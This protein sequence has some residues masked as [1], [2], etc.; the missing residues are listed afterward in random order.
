MNREIRLGKTVEGALVT[1]EMRLERLPDRVTTVEHEVIEP[2][3]TD[4]RFAITGCVYADGTMSDT[5]ANV[6]SAGQCRDSLL[7]IVLPHKGWNLVELLELHDFW[8]SWHLNDMH[9]ACAHMKLPKDQSYEARKNITC[10]V[11]GYKYGHAWL[12]EPLPT[13]VVERIRAFQRRLT[14]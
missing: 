14:P 4:L 9:A 6:T 3:D 5:D 1:V 2:T 11:T 10:P 8:R 13:N 7:D 12:Y